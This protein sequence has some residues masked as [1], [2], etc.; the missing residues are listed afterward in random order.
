MLR[1][2]QQPP[3]IELI[4]HWPT[5]QPVA[6]RSLP[7]RFAG[8]VRPPSFAPCN[9]QAPGGGPSGTPALPALRLALQEET[10]LTPGEENRS[11]SAWEELGKDTRPA[12]DKE[13]AANT[14]DEGQKTVFPWKVIIVAKTRRKLES[15]SLSTALCQM[16][17]NLSF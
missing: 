12:R 11:F 1:W 9:E 17:R 6:P 2:E 14:G 13:E 15:I 10:H 3:L 4:T 7:F 16:Q 5:G 8:A